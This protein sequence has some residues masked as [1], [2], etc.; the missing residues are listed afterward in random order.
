MNASDKAGVIAQGGTECAFQLVGTRA[1]SSSNPGR[2][3]PMFSAFRELMSA[4]G[5]AL[6]KLSKP[7]EDDLD[8]RSGCFEPALSH[9][10]DESLAVRCDV[11]VPRNGQAGQRHCPPHRLGSL[12]CERRLGRDAHRIKIPGSLIKKDFLSIR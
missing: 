6:L 2:T 7:V 9:M 3:G 5:S 1:F 12:E 4:L 11:V 8:L 10:A